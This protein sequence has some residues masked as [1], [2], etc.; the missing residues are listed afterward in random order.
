MVPVY[1]WFEH[2]FIFSVEVYCTCC[3]YARKIYNLDISYLRRS[4]YVFFFTWRYLA[5]SMFCNYKSRCL[6][7]V[8]RIIWGQWFLIHCGKCQGM[9]LPNFMAAWQYIQLPSCSS[10]CK[11]I[12][13]HKKV[14][15]NWGSYPFVWVYSGIFCCFNSEKMFLTDIECCLFICFYAILLALRCF[16]QF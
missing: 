12:S 8:F 3:L 15:R 5:M 4:R 14:G 9:W 11:N 13:H 10:S 2:M 6:K 16:I 1:F 7:F